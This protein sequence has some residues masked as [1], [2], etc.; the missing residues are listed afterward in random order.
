MNERD[1]RL[2]IIIIAA[3]FLIPVALGLLTALIG[4]IADL[5]I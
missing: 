4:F 3:L 5:F 2:A 1:K